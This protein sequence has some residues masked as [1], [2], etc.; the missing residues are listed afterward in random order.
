MEIPQSPYPFYLSTPVQQRFSDCDSFGHVNNS[1]VMQYFD[2]GKIDYF[3]RVLGD[4]FSPRKASLV[5]VNINCQ[6]YHE[7]RLGEPV[8]V[9]TRADSVG[10]R[11]IILEQRIVNPDTGQAKAIAR[12]V[13]A[14][15]DIS[16]D[17]GMPIPA[18]WR[19]SIS[20]YE[21]RQM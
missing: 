17:A 3:N 4:L 21:R 13:M 5:I 9:L 6:F 2:L 14:G 12:V 15:F 11:S 19:A 20:A 8:A 1:V 18:S 10:E 16:A 7:T